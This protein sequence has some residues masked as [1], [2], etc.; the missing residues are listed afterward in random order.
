MTYTAVGLRG[1]SGILPDGTIATWTDERIAELTKLWTEGLSCS[2]IAKRL[3]GVTRSAIIGKVHRLGL[4]GRLEP[5]NAGIAK[6][7]HRRI[8]D[9]KQIASGYF[10]KPKKPVPAAVLADA[11]ASKKPPVLALI[12]RAQTALDP[13]PQADGTLVSILSLEAG[14]CKFPHSDT[15]ADD[16]AF[17]GRPADK[18]TYCGHHHS[19]CFKPSEE[20]RR[21]RAR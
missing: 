10:A 19:I 8:Q 12:R 2:H 18:G 14:M 21:R 4:P 9:Y 6:R 11:A 16:F 13:L 20:Q 17:C 1:N 7:R 15:R 5:N 3:G